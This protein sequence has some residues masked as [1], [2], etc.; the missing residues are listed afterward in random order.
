MHDQEK[1]CDYASNPN[2]AVVSGFMCAE[3]DEEAWAKADG[4][5]FFQ[6]ALQLYNKEGPF[7]PG[8]V[9][10][11]Q[12]YQEWKQTPAG[13]KRSG[14]ELIGSPDTITG[15]LRELEKAHVDQVI[16]LNQA[17]KNSHEDICA[18]LQLFADTVMPE[19]QSRDAEQ[20]AWK[21]AVLN[22]EIQLEE[23]DTEPFNFTA[24]L[25][26]TKPPS[27]EGRD[28]VGGIGGRPTARAIRNT[29]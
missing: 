7:E 24:R 22:G 14:S 10:F 26:P 25:K 4:W 21:T 23:I 17:G 3:T 18:S 12:R 19:F 15:R 27:R 1:L 16:L 2:I 29:S 8:G 20:E 13:Q 28:L 5:T 6:F 11:W 9:N